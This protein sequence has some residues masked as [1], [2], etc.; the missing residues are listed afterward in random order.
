M[1]SY[2]NMSWHSLTIK[3]GRIH[4]RRQWAIKSAPTWKIA[5]L[6]IICSSFLVILYTMY[7]NSTFIEPLY[8]RRKVC[9]MY[10]VYTIRSKMFANDL[11]AYDYMWCDIFWNQ[12]TWLS[13]RCSQAM[14]SK[15]HQ[16]LMKWM[17]ENTSYKYE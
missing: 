14:T 17:Q 13:S 9:T 4:F 15:G 8:V 10:I 11:F 6:D 1:N 7:S 16:W 3:T 12:V 5:I 2:T